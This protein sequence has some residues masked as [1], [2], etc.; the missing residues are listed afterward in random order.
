MTPTRGARGVP[1]FGMPTASKLKRPSL[2]A[3]CAVGVGVGS[4]GSMTWAWFLDLAST[5][6]GP[7]G[8]HELSSS[9]YLAWALVL[10]GAGTL[11]LRAAG[12]VALPGPALTW[13][14]GLPQISA[15]LHQRS[16]RSRV[17]ATAV[18]GGTAGSAAMIVLWPVSGW[19]AGLLPI[20]GPLMGAALVSVTASE[21]AQA[22]AEWH[23]ARLATTQALGLVAVAVGLLTWY[24]ASYDV[25]TVGAGMA[26][27]LLGALALVVLAEGLARRPAVREVIATGGIP[28]GELYRAGE[29]VDRV[30]AS[31]A[32]MTTGL[33]EP[34]PRRQR[35]WRR[36]CLAS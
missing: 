34:A 27:P 3:V 17:M 13:C 9:F 35:C 21:Q 20:V 5:L 2:Y 22:P 29:V 24:F 1:G 31:V 36:P 8:G 11:A 33:L 32:M 6:A 16:L 26:L 14:L 25:I 19:L 18:A 12:P 30:S 23:H 10:T 4:F 15:L 7:G 28:L